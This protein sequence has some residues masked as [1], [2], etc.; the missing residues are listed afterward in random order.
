MLCW[1]SG[2]GIEE[3]QRNKRSTE[4]EERVQKKVKVVTY[5]DPYSATF[6]MKDV[7]CTMCE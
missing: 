6:V 2:A 3:T 5:F 4:E 1:K 7:L